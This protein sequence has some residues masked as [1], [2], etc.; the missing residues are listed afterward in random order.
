MEYRI[1]GA[2]YV[3]AKRDFINSIPRGANGWV[4]YSTGDR[5]QKELMLAMMTS[6]EDKYCH[7]SLTY[8]AEHSKC[9]TEDFIKDMIYAGSGLAPN[10]RREYYWD[11]ELI[12]FVLGLYLDMD[13]NQE[14]KGVADEINYEID[15]PRASSL[16]LE[17][18]SDMAEERD[19]QI[20]YRRDNLANLVSI[21]YNRIN[22][23]QKYSSIF[24]EYSKSKIF[25][26]IVTS[27]NEIYNLCEQ[28]KTTATNSRN[29][30]DLGKIRKSIAKSVD[31][32]YTLEDKLWAVIDKLVEKQAW[33]EEENSTMKKTIQEFS[34]TLVFF[35]K[36]VMYIKNYTIRMFI[37]RLTIR[38]RLDWKMLISEQ[39][40]D[41]EF[42]KKWARFPHAEDKINGYL[43]EDD[44]EVE[45]G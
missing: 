1:C 34:K 33:L 19:K 7:C 10:P 40:L 37:I 18:L 29:Q 12:N 26:K 16:P 2:D 14:S 28:L 13:E 8:A 44:C 21:A 5:T 3:A 32:F 25:D 23:I 11:E 42:C 43:S 39:N 38:N 36:K 4:E 31:A 41:P 35:T 17:Y 20:E 24:K 9:W 22:D 6:Q 30:D 45:E 15:H 27:A